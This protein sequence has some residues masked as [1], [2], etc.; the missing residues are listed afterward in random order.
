M[1][2]RWSFLSVSYGKESG[3]LIEMVDS[4]FESGSWGIL[5]HHKRPAES[6]EK[7]TRDNLK[8]LP[9]VKDG[10]F[11]H[12]TRVMGYIYEVDINPRSK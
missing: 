10:M 12:Q 2:R 1:P 8:G 5:F 9:L 3:I 6:W 11:E 7:V 4:R